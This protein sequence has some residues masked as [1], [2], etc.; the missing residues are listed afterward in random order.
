MKTYDV[1]C[2]RVKF[3][4]GKIGTTRYMSS[5]ILNW[6]IENRRDEYNP[7]IS[8]VVSDGNTEYVGLNEIEEVIE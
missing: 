8:V 2:A 5:Y 7:G 3:S 1:D 6:L 4:G